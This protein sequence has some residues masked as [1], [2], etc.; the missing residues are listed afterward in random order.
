MRLCITAGI[1]PPDIGGPASYVTRI[2]GEL[3][4]RGHTVSV[5]CLSDSTDRDDTCFPFRVLRLRRLLFKPARW[6]A[7]AGAILGV[8]RRSDV[9]FAN[10][11]GFEAAVAARALGRGV[12]HKVVGDT[13]WERAR[14]R[15]WFSG[16]VEEYQ[17]ASKGVRLGLLDWVRVAPLR[18]ADGIIV[19]SRYLGRIVEGW[20][21]DRGRIQ[22]IY[23][24]TEG[25]EPSAGPSLPPTTFRT[26]M[27][28]CRLVPWKGV[29]GLLRI[30]PDLS[31]IR[32]VV[33]GDGPMRL[34]LES[35]AQRY[36]VADRVLF[37]GDVPRDH[38][39][40]YLRQ[41]ELFVLNST[42]EGLPH[43]VLEA[44]AAGVPV[45]A[46]DVGGTGELVTDGATGRLVPP[47]DETAL[48]RAI[49][50]TLTDTEGAR[51]MAERA[52]AGLKDRFSFETMV[53]Q[54]ERVLLG[55]SGRPA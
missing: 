27:T 35:L 36:R 1:F 51:R 19:P 11:L 8:A 3:V 32:L 4:R 6:L 52:Q 41:A 25:I 26:V 33:I 30:L 16:T 34:A 18:R 13:A 22:V 2:A 12:V 7:T 37:L 21:I 43:T 38:V 9:V 48:R 47:G 15:G 23:N 10:G 49:Q 5:V 42:Y 29:D 44:M 28:V 40:G 46:T 17:D 20:G 45:I 39:P 24:A 14:L 31:G 55:V 50:E 54:T 53:D